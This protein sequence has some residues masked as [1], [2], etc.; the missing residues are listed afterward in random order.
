MKLSTGHFW[1]E[2]EESPKR[3]P[4]QPS[5]C[6]CNK[7]TSTDALNF[8]QTIVSY[9]T[10]QDRSGNIRFMLGGYV[11]IQVAAYCTDLLLIII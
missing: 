10:A 9:R 5:Y 2:G 4:P 7:R 1:G 11:Y 8:C 6:D 3:W